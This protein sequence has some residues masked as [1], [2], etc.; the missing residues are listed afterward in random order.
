MFTSH[1]LSYWS[2]LVCR[3]HVERMPVHQKVQ[4]YCILFLYSLYHHFSRLDLIYAFFIASSILFKS[5]CFKVKF[6]PESIALISSIF[7][8]LTS[9][10]LLMCLSLSLPTLTPLN[11]SFMSFTFLSSFKNFFM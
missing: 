11:F 3:N 7:L 4:H 8:G 5:S 2:L 10:I 9:I 6:S 1:S